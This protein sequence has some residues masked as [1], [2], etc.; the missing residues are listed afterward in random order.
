MVVKPYREHVSDH[1]C[2]RWFDENCQDGE[3]VWHRDA[4]DRVVRVLQGNG[5]QFQFDNELPQSFEPGTI[6][7]IEKER[8]HRIIKGS[9]PLIVEIVE[10]QTNVNS[11]TQQQHKRQKLAK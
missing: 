4:N 5:W 6:I 1:I 2:V 3:L 10:D 11:G 7:Y 9:G 8:Y